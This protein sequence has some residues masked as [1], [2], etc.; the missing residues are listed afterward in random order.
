MFNK[1]CLYVQE[2]RNRKMR[3]KGIR[4]KVIVRL[5]AFSAVIVV[6]VGSLTAFMYYKLALE[7]YNDDI[8]S[9]LR[10]ASDFIYGDR[11]D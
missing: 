3:S 9:Y 10:A 2:E 5:F 11:I 4:Q 7:E 8:Y 1:T 6:V